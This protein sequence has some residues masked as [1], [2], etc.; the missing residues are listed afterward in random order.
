MSD[1]P[2]RIP[3]GSE[4]VY[5]A[6]APAGCS[7]HRYRVLGFVVHVPTYQQQVLVEA[8][9]G[10]DRGLRFTCTPHNFS[11]RYQPVGPVGER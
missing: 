7:G 10:P 3:E 2:F 5:T 6:P 9:T 8:L 1:E 4:W 11:T